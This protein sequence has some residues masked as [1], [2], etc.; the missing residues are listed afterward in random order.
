MEKCDMNLEDFFTK[1]AKSLSKDE[2]LD[3]AK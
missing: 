3:F 2:I 1:K